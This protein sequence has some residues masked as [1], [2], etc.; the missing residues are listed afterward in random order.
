MR[1]DEA[2]TRQRIVKSIE[3]RN[4]IGEASGMMIVRMPW[5]TAERI[6]TKDVFDKPDVS[7][8]IYMTFAIR[9]AHVGLKFVSHLDIFVLM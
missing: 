2:Y 3:K 8:Q 1:P 4:S 7:A 5:E 9:R 6:S